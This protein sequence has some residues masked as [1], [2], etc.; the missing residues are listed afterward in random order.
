MAC[1][2]LSITGSCTETNSYSSFLNELC[3][4]LHITV[5]AITTID[6]GGGN[7]NFNFCIDNAIGD[8]QQWLPDLSSLQTKAV[9]VGLLW[10]L[11]HLTYS[12]LPGD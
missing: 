9:F 3:T 1:T 10:L 6:I 7:C 2:N 5:P 12:Y 8:I 4:Q 11:L